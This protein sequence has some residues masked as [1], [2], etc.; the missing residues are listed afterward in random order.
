MRLVGTP[1]LS[2]NY[3]ALDWTA[4]DLTFRY[5]RNGSRLCENASVISTGGKPERKS[6]CED[7]RSGIKT[8]LLIP[9]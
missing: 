2:L 7:R 6:R 5:A 9:H 3:T 8:R 1:R 4:L